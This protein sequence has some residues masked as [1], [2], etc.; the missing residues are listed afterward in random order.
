MS[1]SWRDEF[2]DG[3]WRPNPRTQPDDP[4]VI[5]LRRQGVPDDIPNEDI[6][7]CAVCG[8]AVCYF[9]PYPEGTTH[10]VHGARDMTCLPPW[11]NSRK[12]GYRCKEHA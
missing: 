11:A 1:A 4:R 5:A 6:R 2:R 12:S 3:E 9:H 10:H 7:T 8:I